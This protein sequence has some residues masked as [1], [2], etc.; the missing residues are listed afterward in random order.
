MP[1]YPEIGNKNVIE[2][3]VN[4]NLN[5]KNEYLCYY[6]IFPLMNANNAKK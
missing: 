2:N 6:F 1:N 5:K 3:S 4:K